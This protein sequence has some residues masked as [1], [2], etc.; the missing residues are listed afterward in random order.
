MPVKDAKRSVKL[1]IEDN[2]ITR[3][4]KKSP[5]SCV[6][7]RA[8]RRAF[9]AEEVRVH[10]S[11]VYVKNAKDEWVRYLTPRNLRSE[12][13]AFD[14]GGRFVAGTYTLSK[15]PPLQHAKRGT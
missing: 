8:C 11:R 14:R 2:D 13:I 6:V 4:R 15:V 3:A 1:I 12:I 7:A 10:L 5:E 9:D